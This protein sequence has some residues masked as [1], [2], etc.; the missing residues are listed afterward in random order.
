MQNK[1]SFLA[2]ILGLGSFAAHAQAFTIPTQVDTPQS[3]SKSKGM[4]R[5]GVTG[6]AHAKR[7]ARKARNVRH[8]RR[9]HRG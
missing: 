2:A 7:V 4:R 6:I 8:N 1:L 5:S 3:S 9:M